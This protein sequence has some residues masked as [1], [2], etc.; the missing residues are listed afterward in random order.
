MARAHV[1]LV[2]GLAICVSAS[3]LVAQ[4]EINTDRPDLS[5]IVVPKGSL[6]VENGL[7]WTNNNGRTMLDGMESLVRFGI[8]ASGEL[9]VGLPDYY[10]YSEHDVSGGF[11]DIL[12]GWKQQLT[13]NSGSF[14]FS[15][16]PG[17]SLPTGSRGLTSG[18]FDPQLGAAWSYAM[19]SKWSTSGAQFVYY[20]TENG[21][22]FPEGET[23]L[24]IERNLTRKTG[25]YIEYQSSYGHFGYSYMVE[26]GASYRKRPNYQWDF[27]FGAGRDRGTA[28][29]SVGAGFSFRLG[30]IW[31]RG[32]HS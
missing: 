11:T 16:A 12:L 22:H 32:P 24:A 27:L 21:R 7:G 26:I 18:G 10:G 25:A 31:K 8:T 4:D 5:S 9:R 17:L 29:V 30:N 28:E 6:Q 2:L 1:S 19:S 3:S 23:V 15:I 13:G 14:Q 20:T